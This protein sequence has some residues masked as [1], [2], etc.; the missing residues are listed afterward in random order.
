MI[1]EIRVQRLSHWGAE[2]HVRL[3]ETQ[4]MSKI[5]SELTEAA[6]RYARVRRGHWRATAWSVSG[7]PVASVSVPPDAAASR[8][9]GVRAGRG[10]AT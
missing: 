10:V 8:N 9:G 3:M 6:M 5:M 4:D 2:E 7:M 1:L